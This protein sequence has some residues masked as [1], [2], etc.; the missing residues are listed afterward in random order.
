MARILL[1]DDD[2]DFL[3]V[4]SRLL[5]HTGV[6]VVTCASAMEALDQAQR[7][8]FDVIITDANMKPHSGYEL[9]RSIKAIP[10]YDLIPI[11]MIT[12]R[13][14]K[15]DVERAVAVGAQDYIVKPIDPDRFIQKVRE[16]ISRSE[17]ARRAARFGEVQL[18]EVA[19]MT[20]AVVIVGL[21]ETGVLLDSDHKLFEGSVIT[22]DAELFDKIGCSTPQAK[23]K[24]CIP[25]SV[26]GTFEVRAS[27][28]NLDERNTMKIRQFVQA[29]LANQKKAAR[30]A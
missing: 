7:Y 18:N 10:S 29:R 9:I 1:V 20:T 27:F 30:S 25:G 22:L 3:A 6:E 21:S 14:E 5:Q 4:A 28:Q 15:R 16:L 8:E 17:N 26:E 24:S 11:A 13:R 19:K 12:G 2:H 23:V